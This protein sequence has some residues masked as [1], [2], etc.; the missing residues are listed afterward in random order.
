MYSLDTTHPE[1]LDHLEGLARDLVDAGFAYLKLDFTFAPSVDGRWHDPRRTPAQRVRAG[2]EAIRR[3]AG[4]ETL[5]LGCGVPLANVVGVV[6]ANR[7]GPDV[8]PLWALAPSDE[9]VAGYLDVQPATRSA[10]A[11]TVARSF[12]HRHL[13]LNDPDCLMLRSE[14]TAL[15]A[16]AAETWARCVALSGGLALVSDDLDLL[17]PAARKQLEGIVAMGRE[18]DGEARGGRPPLAP[19]LL[20]QVVPTTLT[21]ARREL[22]TD[23]DA[24]TSELRVR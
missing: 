24:A 8:A 10:Y 13:W 14:D 18:S 23:P 21:T 2:F 1:V 19:D 9:I 5:L 11:A 16:E 17:G 12:M 4:E 7:I 6:D 15:S 3:G 20:A 22:V